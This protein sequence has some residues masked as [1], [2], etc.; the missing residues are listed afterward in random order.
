[1]SSCRC[2]DRPDRLTAG[3]VGGKPATELA[4]RAGDQ[5]PHGSTLTRRA[6]SALSGGP[7]TSFAES[8]GVDVLASGQ[9]MPSLGIVPQRSC[10]RSP[11]RRSPCTCRGNRCRRSS[12]RK[13]CAKPGGIQN[14]SRFSADSSTPTHRPKVG[15]ERRR[16]TATSNTAPPIDAHQL[17]LRRSGSGNAGRAARRAPSGCGCPARSRRRAR[18][19]E[20]P[21]RSRLS[22][23]KPRS[24]PNT[25]GSITSTIGNAGRDDASWQ[26][27]FAAQQPQQVLAVAALAQRLGQSVRAARR[28]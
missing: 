12:T 21:L 22:R 2:R 27:A 3:A 23:K 10:A 13:P 16:S 9:A 25:R 18:L 26:R 15:D 24:S 6:P 17:A 5:R 11:A 19:G 14:S 20:G 28:R 7:A 8:S 1:M 4:A